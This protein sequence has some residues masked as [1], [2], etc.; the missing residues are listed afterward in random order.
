MLPAFVNTPISRATAQLDEFPPLSIYTV[1]L[2]VDD[3]AQRGL[4]ASY[5]SKW[6]HVLPSITGQDLIAR[7]LRPGPQFRSI[8]S[9][10]RGA[11]LDG[12]ISTLDEE[13]R[14]LEKLIESNRDNP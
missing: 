11:W 7:G 6:K 13:A 3:P 4:L 12:K 1:Y 14:L 8:L 2:S 5:A 10:L 9:E